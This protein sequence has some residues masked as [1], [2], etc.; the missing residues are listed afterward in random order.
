VVI[1]GSV[2]KGLERESSDVDVL[3]IAGNR[4]AANGC[5]AGASAAALARFGV[6]LS[7]LIIS[8]GELIRR[9]NEDFVKSMLESYTLVKGKDPKELVMGTETGQ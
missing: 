7:P 3:I 1:F 2:A 8:R 4:E 5:A 6:E 9:Q